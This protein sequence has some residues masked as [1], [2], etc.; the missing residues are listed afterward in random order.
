MILALPLSGLG[1][2]GGWSKH[3]RRGQTIMITTGGRR[4][5]RCR[6]DGKKSKR[7]KGGEEEGEG[8]LKGGGWGSVATLSSAA[9]NVC[10]AEQAP[11]CVAGATK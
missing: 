8:E 1:S 5:G 7:N 3:Q 2:A 11:Y 4:R 6:P 10:N 9:N